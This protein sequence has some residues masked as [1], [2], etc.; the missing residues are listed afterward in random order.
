MREGAQVLA[1]ELLREPVK[2]AVR[3]A[4]REETV[5]VRSSSEETDEASQDQTG[6]PSSEPPQQ[7]GG[8]G[9][10]KLAWM[11]VVLALVGVAYLA[12]QRMSSSG[13]TW[14]EP[15]ADAVA[16]D[17]AES[18]YVSEGQMQTTEASDESEAASGGSDTAPS[19]MTDE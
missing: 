2:E 5:T 12:R 16:G 1:T 8:G 11:G 17:D 13:S 3:E 14:S 6:E 7:R 9:S 15:S 19:T 4:L 10:S 18:G